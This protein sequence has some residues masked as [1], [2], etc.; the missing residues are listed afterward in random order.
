VAVV[1]AV[2]NAGVDEEVVVYAC[3]PSDGS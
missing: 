1:E 3:A 2:V